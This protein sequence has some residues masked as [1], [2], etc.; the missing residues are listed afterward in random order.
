MN[1]SRPASRTNCAHA[2]RVFPCAQLVQIP[3]LNRAHSLIGVRAVQASQGVKS[4]QL[5]NRAHPPIPP[6]GVC[7]HLAGTPEPTARTVAV[8]VQCARFEKVRSEA[9]RYSR[10][11][12]LSRRP[13]EQP[14]I[15]TDFLRL[16]GP[17]PPRPRATTLARVA[18]G[19][20]SPAP[21]TR[22]PSRH[23]GERRPT[24]ANPSPNH[25]PGARIRP[26]SRLQGGTCP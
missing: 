15:Q 9:I 3:G 11:G 19:A 14:P 23:T 2:E 17:L 7:G 26:D 4:A 21:T 16:S 12:S 5:T 1:P 13:R 6:R 8:R 18:A 24:W 10:A 25:R 22:R 20:E